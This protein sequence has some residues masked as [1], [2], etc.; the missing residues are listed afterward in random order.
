M[1]KKK[2]GGKKP[3]AASKK[4]NKTKRRE[5]NPP[6]DPAS[7]MPS[8]IA[9]SLVCSPPQKEQVLEIIR[10]VDPYNKLQP[11]VGRTE[12]SKTAQLVVLGLVVPK[13]IRR[14]PSYKPIERCGQTCKRARTPFLAISGVE[15]LRQVLAEESRPDK[16]W[17]VEVSGVDDNLLQPIL[18]MV[19]DQSKSKKQ[20][21]AAVAPGRPEAETDD[22]DEDE[23]K[24]PME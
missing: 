19:E 14:M 24:L 12:M 13:D 4:K 17:G 9:G 7:R 6:V 3:P 5:K 11:I 8:S 16:I 18:S 21:G 1:K 20:N 2:S 23:D 10:S 22:A 15:E